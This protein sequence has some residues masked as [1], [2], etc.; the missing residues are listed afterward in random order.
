MGLLREE[1]L[2][3]SPVDWRHTLFKFNEDWD[4]YQSLHLFKGNYPTKY[5]TRC[6][7]LL[8]TGLVIQTTTMDFQYETRFRRNSQHTLLYVF[9]W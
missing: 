2:G 1:G 8:R 9:A 7:R 6:G 4:I 5:S 3:P